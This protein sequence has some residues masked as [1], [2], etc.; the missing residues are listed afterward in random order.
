MHTPVDAAAEPAWSG[1]RAIALLGL[2]TITVPVVVVGL[3]QRQVLLTTQIAIALMVGG[4]FLTMHPKSSVERLLRSL[5][6]WGATWLIIGLVL[7]PFEGGIK[8]APETLS[9][10]FTVTG[11]TIMLLVALTV[12]TDALS[13]RRS[14]SALI[15]VG[16]NPLLTYVIYTV[17]INSVLEMIPPM[18]NV[19][20]AS[21]GEAMLRSVI[22]LVIVVLLVRL[23]SRR[24][25]Y[26]RT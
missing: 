11:I 13:K 6:L 22:E 10:F 18:R 25:V 17:L 12:I 9:Y 26:W 1:G 2:A 8:K 16:H 19:L 23:A 3:Y 5:F 20:R 24:R 4:L 7:D 14:V 15:D 21:Q